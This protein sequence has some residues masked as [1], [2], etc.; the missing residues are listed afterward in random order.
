MSYTDLTPE[1][2]ITVFNQCIHNALSN[3]ELS[4]RLSF[5]GYPEEKL[6]IGKSH[7]ELAQQTYN[8]QVNEYGEYFAAS[9]L[10]SAESKS[11][12]EDIK[13]LRTI[14]RV[15]FQDDRKA[16][17]DLKLNKGLSRTFGV[18]YTQVSAMINSSLKNANQLEKLTAYGFD[19]ATLT[20]FSTRLAALP[21]IRE[22]RDRE[23]TEAQQAT[24]ERDE[25]IAIMD[26]WF[27]DLLTIAPIAVKD[28]P[29]LMELLNV[30]VK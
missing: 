21:E 28:K 18:F 24:K 7:G 16:I 15:V 4:S 2:R 20:G 23:N 12:R 3:P 26:K 8:R 1:N 22:D 14:A 10:Y 5:R 11:L 13:D 27:L 30:V 17:Q 9:E 29:E 6:L 25:A 19:E